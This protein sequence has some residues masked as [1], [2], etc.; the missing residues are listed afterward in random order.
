M[1][2]NFTRSGSLL[3]AGVLLLAAVG[4]GADATSEEQGAELGTETQALDSVCQGW[5]LEDYWRFSL[6]CETSELPGRGGNAQC[7]LYADMLLA[8]CLET[9]WEPEWPEL[10]EPE[11]IPTSPPRLP[12]ECPPGG[13]PPPTIP[14]QSGC[15]YTWTDWCYEVCD[16]CAWSP[17]QPACRNECDRVHCASEQPQ[18]PE[19]EPPSCR[20]QMSGTCG[21]QCDWVPT[22]SDCYDACIFQNCGW[23]SEDDPPPAPTNPPGT[24][25]TCPGPD[26]PPR[27]ESPPQYDCDDT[28]VNW[29]HGLCDVCAFPQDIAPCK[30][31]CDNDYC[32]PPIP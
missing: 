15:D 5:C 24:P 32:P 17:D 8:Q 7:Y 14:E 3:G 10:P 9:C 27:P 2:M 18:Q 21:A 29:C 31:E 6:S 22:F 16:K 1:A 11:P 26:G 30:A 12:P 23:E 13:P 28:W 4:C 25:S 20:E 19:P